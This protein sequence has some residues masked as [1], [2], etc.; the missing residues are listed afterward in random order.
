MNR[1]FIK[2]N[3]TNILLYTFIYSEGSKTPTKNIFKGRWWETRSILI[4]IRFSCSSGL[5]E[6]SIKNIKN[7][8]SQSEEMLKPSPSL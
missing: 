8:I 7:I 5:K 1:K 3:Q 4:G 2:N 6:T